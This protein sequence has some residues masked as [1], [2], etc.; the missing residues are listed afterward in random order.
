M[1]EVHGRGVLTSILI[2]VKD[3]HE[4][5]ISVQAL[6]ILVNLLSGGI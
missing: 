1:M 3:S 2:Y 5:R 4:L 6:R